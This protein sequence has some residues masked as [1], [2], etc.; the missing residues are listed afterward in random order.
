[1]KNVMIFALGA[2][3]GS[4]VTWKFVEQKYKQIADEEI[5]SVIER[6]KNKDRVIEKLTEIDELDNTVKDYSKII[7]SQGYVATVTESSPLT[8]D[9]YT[10][11]VDQGQEIVTPYIITP[12][13]FGENDNYETKTWM[14]YADSI[15]ADEND[16]IVADPENIIGDALSHFGEHSDDSVYV[17]DENIGCDYEILLSEKT[18]DEANGHDY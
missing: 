18:F 10:V 14:F 15:L 17:R 8:D 1:M 13:E 16:E 9:D 3:V 4:L 11:T 12:E 6:F 5:E 7:K 2:A